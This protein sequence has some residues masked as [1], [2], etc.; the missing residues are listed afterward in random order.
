MEEKKSLGECHRFEIKKTWKVNAMQ[1]SKL[2]NGEE[3]E[4]L[5]EKMVKT[6]FYTLINYIAPIMS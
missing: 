2:N 4:I 3:K 5:E 1:D 6:K